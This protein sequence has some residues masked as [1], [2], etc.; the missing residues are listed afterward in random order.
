[1][2]EEDD[3]VFSL[4]GLDE[5]SEE[6]VADVSEPEEPVEKTEEPSAF[7]HY[8]ASTDRVD[9][10][11]S[12]EDENFSDTLKDLEKLPEEEAEGES[13]SSLELVEIPLDN[14]EEKEKASRIGHFFFRK[15]ILFVPFFFL[16]GLIGRFFALGERFFGRINQFFSYIFGD[17]RRK[18]TAWLIEKL[19][20][21]KEQLVRFYKFVKAL[22]WKGR[23]FIVTFVGLCVVL[24]K[25][26]YAI[27]GAQ[28]LPTFNDPEVVSIDHHATE[29]YE[30]EPRHG[31]EAFDSPLR[32]PEYVVLLRRVT[33]N[34][35]NTRWRKGAI[36]VMQFY[37]QASNQEVAVEIKNREPEVL[38]HVQRVIEA[39]TYEELTH[40]EGKA[41]I[42]SEIR[43][44]VNR[45]LSKGRVKKVFLK[46]MILKP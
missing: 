5:I 12:L 15:R 24:I 11:L 8:K 25:F 36:G 21:V 13:E 40:P 4:E 22:S 29:E 33:V 9:Q 17:G 27:V 43:K 6:E 16:F 44:V 30:F 3:E 26:F 42:K 34:L 23:V 45:S 14:L 37:L 35:R 2:A 39:M 32:N 46:K 10:I 7:D 31:Y 38:D 41:I 1:M 19:K 18:A 20:W 28:F